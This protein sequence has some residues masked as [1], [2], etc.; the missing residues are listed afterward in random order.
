[1]QLIYD[2]HIQAYT[3]INTVIYKQKY[4]LF[5]VATKVGIQLFS[6]KKYSTVHFN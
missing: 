3:K 4:F 2:D 1:M 6:Y 5:L